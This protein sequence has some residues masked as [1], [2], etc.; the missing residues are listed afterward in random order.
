MSADGFGGLVDAAARLL[1]LL[2]FHDYAVVSRTFG[3]GPSGDVEKVQCR[4]CG[5]VTTRRG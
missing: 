3:F 1:C 2:G 5:F 4:R